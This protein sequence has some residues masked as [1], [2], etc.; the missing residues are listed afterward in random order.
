MA[1]ELTVDV[2]VAKELCN[3]IGSLC[4]TGSIGQQSLSQFNAWGAVASR[5]VRVVG[6]HSMNCC[7]L[8]V[9]PCGSCGMSSPQRVY[10][11]NL[12]SIDA[13]PTRSIFTNVGIWRVV[14]C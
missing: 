8:K 6:Q 2:R 3:I 14:D 4:R 9:V 13:A 12:F 7:W 11:S 1:D 10:V 5:R